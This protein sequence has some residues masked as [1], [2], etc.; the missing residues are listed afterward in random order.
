MNEAI[1]LRKLAGSVARSDPRPPDMQAWQRDHPDRWIAARIYYRFLYAVA[2]IFKPQV[3]VELGTDHGFGAWHLAAGNPEGI[4]IA[5]DLT[6]ER[7]E[8]R[9]NNV[10]HVVGDSSSEEIL[11]E[12]KVAALY[13][14]FDLVFFDSTHSEK[15][16]SREFELYDPLCR[17]GA[18]QF[19]D[20][21]TE[22]AD[23]KRFWDTLPGPK[24]ELNNLHTKWGK[25][26]PGFGARIKP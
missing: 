6:L 7:V 14:P 21:V 3:M 4:V 20:D 16:T 9:P 22:S 26:D 23:I 25:R 13:R 18:F 24:T 10:V 2:H 5:V 8:V 19:F 11:E 12:V 15:H 17:S 1:D